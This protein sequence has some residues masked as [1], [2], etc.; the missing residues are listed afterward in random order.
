[1]STIEAHKATNR[2]STSIDKTPMF[3]QGEVVLPKVL[4]HDKSLASGSC[5]FRLET[6]NNL[7]GVSVNDEFGA[8]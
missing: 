8:M 1:M 5:I 2:E 7:T 6:E 3:N 4:I